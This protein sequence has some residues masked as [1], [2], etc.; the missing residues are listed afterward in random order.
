LLW[1]LIPQIA[2]TVLRGFVAS[3]GRP[4]IATLIAALAIVVNALGNYALVFGNFGA[5]A[6]GLEGSAISTIITSFITLFA[7]LAAIQWNR[8]MRRYRILGRWW[9]PDWQR[10]GEIARLGM[11]I[12]LIVIAEAG[13]FASA[14]FL[15]GLLGPEQIAAHTV[16][17]Q[18]AAF[19]FQVPFGVAQ[20][21]TIRVGFGYGAN[22]RAAA[23]RAGWAGLLVCF[24]F[25][26][27]A[28]SVMLLFPKAVLS[29]YVDVDAPANAAML[30]FAMKYLVVAAAFQLFDGTQAVAAGALRGLQDTRVPM[31]LALFGYWCIGFGL[32]AGLGFATPL[33][34][35]G[36]W[37][38]LAMG[39]VAVALLL[40]RRW[41]RRERLG[42]I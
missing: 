14:A 5:P 29:I 10:L 30:G 4:V 16:A 3:L 42:L 41:N 2:C 37:I 22:D 6:M 39:L 36:V 24:L 20:A 23:G 35:L 8:R 1:S 19:A 13:F 27:C 21:V 32:A 12:A 17:L 40:L 18:V 11:P 38:G 26:G 9:R 25:A 15:M 34:G 33:G 7:Y 31:I 28:A